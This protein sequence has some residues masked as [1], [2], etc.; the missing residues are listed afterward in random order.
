MEANMAGFRRAQSVCILLLV[1]CSSEINGGGGSE[2]VEEAVTTSGNPNLAS[3]AAHSCVIFR[4]GKVLCWGDNTYGQ[5]GNGGTLP[6]DRPVLVSGI[7]SAVAVATGDSHS[8]ATLADGTL[9]CWGRNNSGQL[10]NS[11]TINSSSPVTVTGI[12]TATAIATG[13]A[14]SCARLGNSTVKCW[15]YGL[16]SQL[17]NGSLGSS[18]SPV[19]VTGLTTATNIAAGTNH[20]CARLSNS[21]LRCW[22]NNDRGQLGNGNQ[23]NQA[24]PVAVNGIST[25]TDVGAGWSH[26]CARLSDS[27][28][29][30]WGRNNEGQAGN[31]SSTTTFTSPVTVSGISTATSIGVG[32][33]HACARLSD[34]SLKCW[35]W[36]DK[37]QLG[38]GQSG[39][40]SLSNVPVS[41]IGIDNAV[42]VTGGGSTTSNN[43]TCALLNGGG[44]KCWG[45]NTGGQVGQGTA[46]IRKLPFVV[47][48]TTLNRVIDVASGAQHTCVLW[49]SGAVK[50]WGENGSGQLGNGSTVDSASPV[51]VI[52]VSTATAISAGFHHTCVRLTDSTVKCW[53]LGTSGQLGNGSTAN[54][55]SPVTVS[56]I[57]SATSIGLGSRHSC[58]ALSDGTLRCWGRNTNG[59]LGNAS[60][61]SSSV[62]VTVSGVS[63]AVSVAGGG[64]N[65]AT[66]SGHTCAVSSGG[67][68]KCWGKNTYGQLGDAST[69]QRTTPVAVSGLGSGVA[70]VDLGMYA[71]C[72]LLGDG[73]A[74]CWGRNNNGQLGDGTNTQRTSPVSVSNLTNATSIRGATG[75]NHACAVLGN[76]NVV[77]WGL[78]ASGQLGNGSTTSSTTP[79]ASMGIS[80]AATIGA[81]SD[82]T[83]ARL[84]DSTLVCW[85]SDSSNQLS[86]GHQEIIP[87]P[88][89]LP[90]ASADVERS[91]Y[92]VGITTANMPDPQFNG[93]SADLDVHRVKPLFFPESCS[94]TKAIVLVHGRTVEAVSAFDLQYQDYSLMEQLALSGIDTFTLNHL[95]FGRSSGFTAMSDACNGSLP[96]CLG[97]G[98]T[99][100]PPVG[101]LC[102]CGPVPTFGTNDQNQQGSTRYLNPNPLSA[103]CPHTTNTRFIST[104]TMVADVD[105]VVNDALARTGLP[106]VNLLGYSA[107]GIDVGNYLGDPD[108][109]ARAAHTAKVERAV[110]VSSLFGLPQV[111]ATEPN[112]PTTVHSFPM[113]V[114]DRT[115]ATNGGFNLAA[116]ICPGQRD[117]GIVDPIWTSVKARDSVGAGWGPAQVPSANA[118]LS[119]FAHAT[120]WGWNGASAAQIT[121]PVLVM[122]GLKD[123]VVAVASSASLYGALTGTSSK[124]IVQIG[125]ASHSIFWEGCSGPTCNG[126][127]GPHATI[128]KNVNDWVL[129]GMIYASPG[130]ENGSFGSTSADG[131]NYHTDTPTSDGPA[132]DEGNQL[133]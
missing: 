101:V 77:C 107:G 70:A 99:C 121:V 78:N 63:D 96:A 64:D 47:R 110:F 123:N 119:R 129:T 130:S 100:P 103:L 87:T 40:F 46:L 116:P 65:D 62:P 118:G 94:A 67:G 1:G 128:R 21:A 71:S 120:R 11:T 18:S 109:V 17:G 124:T 38:N 26:T 73:T 69:T 48:G 131:T 115:S 16:F 79:V 82:H 35:G 112:T 45:A 5:L 88:T 41:V 74:K 59:E 36:N 53:G 66:G 14:H 34:G 122:H 10:G 106:K 49:D 75:G 86:A 30:C 117:D 68:V 97:I 84:D 52:G 15:G 126:W 8:C 28:V 31:G 125:C 104:T 37:G 72:A 39:F 93:L 85:G 50:C 3:G 42:A 90:C 12:S 13:G 43:F 81:G 56:G 102:D 44:V 57:S 91:D 83:C 92:Y 54:A 6:S 108:P 24:T 114:M 19:S 105:A 111:T 20:T 25:A 61:T 2:S 133:P 9:R 29:R 51:D 98:Q 95:G 23:T 113:G 55:T 60:T 32:P 76:K 132:A 58:A 33:M 89:A 27:T 22:G 4:A 80:R 127:T 7:T